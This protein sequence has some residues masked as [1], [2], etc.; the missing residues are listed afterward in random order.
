MFK[1]LILASLAVLMITIVGCFGAEEDV[2]VIEDTLNSTDKIETQEKPE[3]SAVIEKPEVEEDVSES[4]KDFEFDILSRDL[5]V[6]TGTGMHGDPYIVEVGETFTGNITDYVT[7]TPRLYYELPAEPGTSY[8]ATLIVTDTNMDST[9]FS[10]S[11]L[12]RDGSYGTAEVG[13]VEGLDPVGQPI[14][15]SLTPE[16]NHLFVGI[17]A[18]ALGYDV[19]YEFTVNEN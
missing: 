15:L 7:G 5:E 6:G 16:S 2:N 12:F 3:E 11:M 14:E 10:V 18:N 9:H 1:N 8:T 17:E 19:F 4:D 13:Q